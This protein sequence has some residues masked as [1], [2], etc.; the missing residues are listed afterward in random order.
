MI[1]KPSPPDHL[2]IESQNLWADIATRYTLEEHHLKMLTTACEAFDRQQAARTII[3][4][5]GLT[6]QNRFGDPVKHPAVAV[7]EAAET[8]FLKAMR[9]LDLDGS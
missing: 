6:Y 9:A 2:T 4:A 3:A 7:E 5:E 8:A 1:E